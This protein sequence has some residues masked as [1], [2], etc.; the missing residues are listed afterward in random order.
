MK[1]ALR[2]NI[3]ITKTVCP[4]P[5]VPK[6][7]LDALAFAHAS[8]LS[9]ISSVLKY[10]ALEATRRNTFGAKICPLL[11]LGD[12]VKSS[13]PAAAL[14][15]SPFLGSPGHLSPRGRPDFNAASK[16]TSDPLRLHHFVRSGLGHS[17]DCG[18]SIGAGDPV[19][20]VWTHR[21]EARLARGADQGN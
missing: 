16:K 4:A 1:K 8:T 21:L 15:A 19:R 11:L 3:P 12:S 2:P 13:S 6:N 9:S 14:V 20:S 5:T 17:G 18:C 10:K 7:E